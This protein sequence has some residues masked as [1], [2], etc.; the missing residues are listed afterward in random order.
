V[1][2]LRDQRFNFTMRNCLEESVRR[3]RNERLSR[4]APSGFLAFRQERAVIVYEALRMRD[5]VNSEMAGDRDSQCRDDG[6]CQ[7]DADEEQG[8]DFGHVGSR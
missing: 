8:E 5:R 3:L 4:R 1:C 7:D 6:C 2:T